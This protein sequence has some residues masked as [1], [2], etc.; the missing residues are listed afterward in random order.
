MR[1]EEMWKRLATYQPHANKR[2]YGKAWA[3]MCKER[4]EEAARVAERAAHA[5]EDWPGE[6]WAGC[7]ADAAWAVEAEERER[8]K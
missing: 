2:G 5:E 3:K 6:A 1:I 4:T 7:A 8:M